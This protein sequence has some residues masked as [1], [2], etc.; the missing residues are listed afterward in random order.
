MINISEKTVSLLKS[1]GLTLVTAE[2][3]TGGLIAKMITDVSGSSS[4]FE[5]G[6]VSYSNRIKTAILGVREETLA[7]HGAVSE[8]TVTEM[9]LGAIKAS[10]ADVS[11]AVS[12]IAG[13]L[14]DNTSKPVG[15]IWLAVCVNGKVTT[16]RLNN[17][18]D[19][20]IRENNRNSAANEALRLLCETIETAV[21]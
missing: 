4:V 13:P 16:K 7:E 9:A 2:S 10:G 3:C 15:L 21:N 1:S 12:G 5:C 8:E 11:V 19:V 18:F 6:I 14:S 17:T 20:N